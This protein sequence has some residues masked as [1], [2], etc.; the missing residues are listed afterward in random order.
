MHAS[1]IGWDLERFL[2]VPVNN[3]V[4]DPNDLD[5]PFGKSMIGEIRTVELFKQFP[6]GDS[7]E[8]LEKRLKRDPFKRG[9]PYSF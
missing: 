2:Y 4:G 6:R 5:T 7:G 8:L 1:A 3:P 9:N